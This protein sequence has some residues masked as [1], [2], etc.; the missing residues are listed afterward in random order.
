MVVDASMLAK[1]FCDEDLSSEARQI[2][3]GLDEIWAPAHA[4]AEFAEVLHRKVALNEM[5]WEQCVLAL[6]AIVKLLR[7]E[8]LDSLLVPASEIARE[9]GCSVYDAL[10]V[11]LAT[12]RAEQLVTWDKR[13]LSRVEG[14]RYAKSVRSLGPV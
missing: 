9:I 13:L 14:T 5:T 11:A 6:N 7:D 10:Y 2:V 4:L 12:K 1:L 3:G 8:P